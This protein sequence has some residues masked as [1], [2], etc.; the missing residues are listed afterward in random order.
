MLARYPAAQRYADGVAGHDADV[1]AEAF[2][3]DATLLDVDRE[4]RGR[5]QIR[6]WAVNEV[7]G[8]RLTVLSVHPRADGVDLLVRFVPPPG[9]GTGFAAWYCF[10]T[11]GDIITAARLSY[12]RDN[13]THPPRSTSA[14]PEASAR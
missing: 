3:V 10:D 11:V 9:T 8:G 2:A 14:G 12:A 13:T 1:L 4:F 7:I 6:R 5:E